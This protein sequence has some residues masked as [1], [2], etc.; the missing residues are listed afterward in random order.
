MRLGERSDST[1]AVLFFRKHLMQDRSYINDTI[2]SFESA[3]V[4]VLPL[5]TQ[6]DIVR[7]IVRFAKRRQ[8]MRR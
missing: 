4:D 5:S 3:G 1:V 2:C 6:D 8:Q 7:S